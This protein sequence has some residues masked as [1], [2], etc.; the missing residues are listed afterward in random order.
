M[1]TF[2]DGTVRLEIVGRVAVV[3]IDN[4]PVNAV[5]AAVRDGIVRAVEAACAAPV[6]AGVL[7]CAGRTFVAGADIAEFGKPPVPPHLPDVI[8]GLEASR[9]PWVAAL[10]GSVLGGGLELALGCSARVAAPGT[11][12]GFPEV[13]LGI[14]PGAGGTVR[15]TRLLAAAEAVRLVSEG[16]PIGAEE[17]LRLG[18]IDAVADGDPVTEAMAHAARLAGAPKPAP[19]SERPPRD[20]PPDAFWD[21]ARHGIVAKA[22]GQASPPAALDAVRDGILLD[23]AEA[24]AGERRRFLALRDSDQAAALRHVFFAERGTAV[25]DAV[26]RATARPIARIAIV[27]GGT[28]GAGIAAAILLAG[29]GAII[30]ERDAG[31]A[32]AAHDRVTAILAQSLKRGVVTPEA[33]AAISARFRT[34]ALYD[35]VADCDL[36]IEAVFEDMDAKRAVFEAFDRV[37]RDDAVLVSNTSY[38]DVGAIA[39]TVR[40][41]SRVIGLHFF[42]PA[43]IM[44]LVEIVMPDGASPEALATG[45]ALTKR[46]RKTAIFARVCDGFIGNRIMSAYR[47]DCDVMLEEGASPRIVDG[48]MRNF[49]FAMGIYAVQDLAGLDISWAMRKRQVLER[50]DAARASAIPDRLCEQ[51]RFGRKTGAGWYD[52]PDGGQAGVASPV[53]AGI[54]AAERARAGRPQRAFTEAMVMDRIVAR[55]TA[56]ARAVLDEGVAL[57]PADID[58]AMILGYGFPRFRGGPMFMAGAAPGH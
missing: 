42:S 2:G 23:P 51:G 24:L 49:G 57:A 34:T 1:T 15:L 7:T 33:H 25:P 37:M 55:M 17:A 44:K 50:P 47:R 13:G 19:L 8:L 18:L 41:P 9:L 52:Y 22:R 29:L 10:H 20:T 11:R 26:T 40:D 58:V 43:H 16:K 4:P 35:D 56:E 32:T 36:A 12:L 54:I 53:V 48:A 39:A 27:G 21:S 46:L 45:L 31:A 14:I 30:V 3:T 28:M 5:S 38:L 6:D